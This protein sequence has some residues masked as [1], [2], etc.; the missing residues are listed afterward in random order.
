MIDIV[1]NYKLLILFLKILC[2][3]KSEIFKNNINSL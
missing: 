3:N 2:F 1:V